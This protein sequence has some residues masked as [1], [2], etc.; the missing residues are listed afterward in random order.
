MTEIYKHRV[1]RELST[2][3]KMTSENIVRYYG[4]WFEELDQEEMEMELKYQQDF[5]K[6]I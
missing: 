5:N 2:T 1:Y 4:S 3:A 6:I